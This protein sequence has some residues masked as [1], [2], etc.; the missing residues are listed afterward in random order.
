LRII[1]ALFLAVA[2]AGACANDKEV[3]EVKKEKEEDGGWKVKSIS[4]SEW[5]TV[6]VESVGVRTTC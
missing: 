5:Q 6:K 3:R 2:A 4:R 1:L